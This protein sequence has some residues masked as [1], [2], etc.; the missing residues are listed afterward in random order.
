[1]RDVMKDL[2]PA[3]ICGF[4]FVALLHIL[5][6]YLLRLVKFK[7]TNQRIETI[8]LAFAELCINMYQSIIN[9]FVMGSM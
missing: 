8:H 4:S 3:Y 7:P 2:L 1:M 9:I 5:G 6:L